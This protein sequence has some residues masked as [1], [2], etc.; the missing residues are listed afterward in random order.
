VVIP[1]HCSERTLDTLAPASEDTSLE[2][3]SCIDWTREYIEF[4][5]GVYE[6]AA[7]G[8]ELAARI[9]ERYPDVKGNDFGIEWLARLL[10]P[11]SCPDWFAPLPG[12]PGEIFLNPFGH[13]DGDPPRE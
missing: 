13:Y 1:G 12:E 7:S 6:T 10:F 8:G 2:C 9:K 4:Y 11:R 5:E 3:T